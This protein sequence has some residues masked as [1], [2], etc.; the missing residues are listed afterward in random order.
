[1]TSKDFLKVIQSQRNQKKDEKFSGTFIDYLRLVSDNPSLVK[2]AHKRLYESIEKKGV[3]TLDVD[4]PD[5]RP[6]FN[7]D[8]LRVYDYFSSEFY[9]MESPINKLL[10]FFRI[11][12]SIR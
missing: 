9:G 5:Y 12:V 11:K 7:G 10:R 3:K 8:K 2:L 6:I 4:S 1:M